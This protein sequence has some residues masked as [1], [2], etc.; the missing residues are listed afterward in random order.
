MSKP[1]VGTT[2]P[3]L[4][5]NACVSPPSHVAHAVAVARHEAETSARAEAEIAMVEAGNN[6][7]T[8]CRRKGARDGY[9]EF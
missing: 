6:D 3:F 1:R 4:C 5:S 8:I 2:G 7:V 9:F